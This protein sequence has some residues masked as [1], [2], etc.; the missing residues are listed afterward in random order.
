MI[1][2]RAHMIRP[3]KAAL[4]QWLSTL[5]VTARRHVTL[6]P[7]LDER[8]DC[9]DVIYSHGIVHVRCRTLVCC[10]IIYSCAVYEYLPMFTV[11]CTS[12]VRCSVLAS[13]MFLN[14]VAIFIHLSL[15]PYLRCCLLAYVATFTRLLCSPTF[16]LSRLLPCSPKLILSPTLLML[17]FVVVGLNR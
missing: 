5:S 10:F 4:M 16:R 3:S 1:C 13:V 6:A 15:F 11:F 12:H 17:F 8:V 2:V 9:V 14:S 7:V